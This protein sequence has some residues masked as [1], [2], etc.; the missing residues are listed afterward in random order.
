LYEEDRLSDV[1]REKEDGW[2]RET[3]SV[4]GKAEVGSRVKRLSEADRIEEEVVDGKVGSLRN[5]RGS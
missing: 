3:R 4:S 2:F 1:V 5:V